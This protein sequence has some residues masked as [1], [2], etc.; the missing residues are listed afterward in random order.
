MEFQ[1]KI[2]AAT[3]DDLDILNR[4]DN[5]EH[6]IVSDPNDDWLWETELQKTPP[7]RDQLIASVNEKPIG[8]IQIIDPKEEESHYWGDVEENFRA[9]DIWIGEID[10][11]NKG[12]GTLM[13]KHAL[14]ICFSN[15]SIKAVLIDPLSNNIRA[16][17]FYQR[18]GFNP[19]GIRM[20]G[21]D[22]CLVHI[23]NRKDWE[24]SDRKENQF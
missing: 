22:E 13:M 16:H 14:Q 19:V 24:K 10:F 12:F 17:T 15:P 4:W 1:L 8:F 21:D 6:V 23:L 7:W 20:F 11:L 3:I 18:L 2:R 5:E 9:I